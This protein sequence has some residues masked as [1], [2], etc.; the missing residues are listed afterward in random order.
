MY[1]VPTVKRFSLDFAS[2][3]G[4]RVKIVAWGLMSPSVP[5]DQMTG[6]RLAISSIF[7][8]VRLARSSWNDSVASARV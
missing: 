6:T 5:P 7:R 4:S 3:S 2:R 8:F 1:A